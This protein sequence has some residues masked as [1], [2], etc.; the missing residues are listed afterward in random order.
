MG[1]I[2]RIASYIHASRLRRRDM[3]AVCFVKSQISSL[4]GL[5]PIPFIGVHLRTSAAHSHFVLCSAGIRPV[6]GRPLFCKN[7]RSARQ[8]APIRLAS[9]QLPATGRNGFV[10]STR[11]GRA[12]RAVCFVKTLPRTCRQHSRKEPFR[13]VKRLKPIGNP[14]RHN[15]YRAKWLCFFDSLNS[16]QPGA[17]PG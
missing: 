11:G 16:P 8:P 4:P 6:K 1:L 15:T 2:F 9:L 14:N 17:E 5:R 3:K 12:T 10:F 13:F 7:A